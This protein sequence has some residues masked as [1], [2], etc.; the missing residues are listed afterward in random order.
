MSR[1]QKIAVVLGGTFPHRELISNL[2]KRGYYTILADFLENPSAKHVAD[3]HIQIST[4]DKE[5]VL[6]L[7]LERKASLVISTCVDQA[8]VTACFVAEKLGLPAP[9][10]YETSLNVT[11]KTL[12]KE[13]L[14]NSDIKT[15]H[16]IVTSSL[17]DTELSHLRFPLIVKPT[18]SNS[19]K[20]VNRVN[21]PLELDASFTEALEL[22]REKSVIIE[23]FIHGTEIGIDCYIENQEATVLMVK[24]RRKIHL[25]TV[26]EQQIYGCIWPIDLEIKDYSVYKSVAEKIAKAFKLLNTPL[27]IQAIKNDDSINVIEFGA[28]IGGGESF[29]IIKLSTGFDYIDAAVQSFLNEKPTLKFTPPEFYYA[30]TFIY[31]KESIISHISGVE[32]LIEKNII[33]SADLLKPKGSKIG[34]ELSSNN[35]V[36]VFNVKSKNKTDLFER[37]NHAIRKIEVFDINGIPVMRKDIYQDSIVK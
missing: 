10:S 8:N 12:M 34:K 31:A 35:R 16:Y 36:G 3:E 2:Q 32:E 27:M 1:N 14:R 7:C 25:D 29:R 15:P 9:Y 5:A 4:L 6:E 18:D 20:G 33:E 13:L 22:S 24:E 21:N 26:N 11:N 23:E 30:E 37:I 28:R 17:M 19:S